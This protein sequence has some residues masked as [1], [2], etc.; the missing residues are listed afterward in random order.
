MLLTTFAIAFTTSILLSA[1]CSE[2][3]PLSCACLIVA[4]YV[5]GFAPASNNVSLKRLLW[6]TPFGISINPK[7]ILIER[8]KSLTNDSTFFKPCSICLLASLSSP[9]ITLAIVLPISAAVIAPPI[10]TVSSVVPVNA[11]T[12]FVSLFSRTS[13]SI[14]FILIPCRELASSFCAAFVSAL[15]K[16]ILSFGSAL[17]ANASKYPIPVAYKPLDNSLASLPITSLACS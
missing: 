12:T 2:I 13:L 4:S 3:I 1:S 15:L 8:G 11:F 17:N 6:L 16:N 10:L 5:S 7:G 9:N 14:F